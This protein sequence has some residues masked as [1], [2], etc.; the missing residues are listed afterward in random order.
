MY[1]TRD[2]DVHSNK[3]T[4]CYNVKD[5]FVYKKDDAERTV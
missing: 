3:I 1:L 5:Y 2:R 4:I